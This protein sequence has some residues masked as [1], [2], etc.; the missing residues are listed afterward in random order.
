MLGH[1]ESIGWKAYDPEPAFFAIADGVAHDTSV[2]HLHV[3]QSLAPGGYCWMFPGAQDSVN[4]GVLVGSTYRR[5][6]NIRQLLQTFISRDFP[7]ARIRS[8]HAGTI[9]CGY[10]RGPLALHGLIKA[11]D[12]A[13][14]TNPMSRAGIC[15]ALRSGLS[16]AA[17]AMEMLDAGTD[18][19]IARCCK[20]Y[21]AQWYRVLGKRHEKLLETKGSLQ[22]VP[23]RDYDAAVGT[24]SAIP[25]GEL[26]MARIF[27]VALQRFP[28]LVWA[29]RHLM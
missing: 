28:R 24:L 4:L 3:G 14:T 6:A 8:Y 2:V 1:G 23:D 29:M 7:S 17:C 5:N 25:A 13:N 12:A 18:R 27:R 11:G 16:A 10:R 19:E 21:E 9:A 26:T 20:R 15:E 22:K